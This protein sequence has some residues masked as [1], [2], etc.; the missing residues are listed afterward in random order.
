MR[1]PFDLQ[2]TE[3][4]A[5]DLNFEETLTDEEAEQV[6]GGIRY[7]HPF[8]PPHYVR[9]P[10]KFPPIEPCP[11]PYDPTPPTPYPEEPP[12]MTTLAIG[13]EGGSEVFID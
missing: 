13:E 1:H 10:I 7:Y 6:G 12:I 2:Q 3:L 8:K 5:L 4:D 11:L 9:P